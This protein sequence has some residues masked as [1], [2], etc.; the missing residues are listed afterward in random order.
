LLVASARST[1]SVV[2]FASPQEMHGYWVF[3][4]GVTLASTGSAYYHL[5][6]D[7]VRLVWDHLPMTIAFPSLVAVVVSEWINVQAGAALIWPLVLLGSASVVYWR[8]SALAHTDHGLD[9]V[10]RIAEHLPCY[11]VE[12]ADLRETCSLIGAAFN[13]G[14]PGAL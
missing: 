10:A 13:Q 8:W 4:A 2:R 9:A 5:A 7:D 6:P 1:G 14:L 12:S 11:A 3:F